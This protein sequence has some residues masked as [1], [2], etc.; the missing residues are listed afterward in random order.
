MQKNYT[1]YFDLSRAGLLSGLGEPRVRA[2]KNSA[3]TKAGYY[4][5]AIPASPVASTLYSIFDASGRT[6]AYTTSAS[7]TQTELGAGLLTSLR[8]STLYSVASAS[9]SANVLTVTARS[10]VAPLVLTTVT[11]PAGTAF[12]AG[13]VSVAIPFGAF[14]ARRSSD[15]ADEARLP[16]LSTDKL[17]GVA[18][19]TYAIEK[20]AKGTAAKV[21]YQPNEAMDILDRCNDMDGIWVSCIEPDLNLADTLYVSVTAPTAGYLTRNASGTIALVNS[22]LVRGSVVNSDGTLMALLSVNFY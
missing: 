15:L 2:Y 10:S 7:P 13:T 20:D 12:N 18:M 21:A 22:S 1:Q 17:L 3:D 4:T 5:F 16:T 6:A 19:S 11:L 9:L 8:R 14:V